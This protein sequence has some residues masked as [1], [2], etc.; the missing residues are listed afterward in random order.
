MIKYSIVVPVYNAEKYLS[1]AV[2]SVLNQSFGNWELV[3]VN[4]G[5]TDGSDVLC[6]D[7][8][9]TDARVKYIKKKNGGVSETRNVGIENSSGEYIVFLDADDW[10]ET[11]C[12]EKVETVINDKKSDILIMNYY[13]A[14]ENSIEKAQPITKSLCGEVTTDI[15]ELIKFTLKL[16]SGLCDKWHGI[17]RPVWAKVFRRDI[18]RDNQITF[19]TQLKIGEDAAFLFHYLQYAK[20]VLYEDWYV[21]YYRDNAASAMNNR[22]WCGTDVSRYYF[23]IV[24]E[25]LKDAI[26]EEERALFWFNIA[27]SDWMVLIKSNLSAV[28]KY[29]EMKKI[30]SD[31]EYQRFSKKELCRHFTKKHKLAAFF[32]RNR[33]P[34]MLL[35]MY[36]V[37]E[38]KKKS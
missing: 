20:T 2:E 3:L 24:E 15:T 1:H 13:R 7:Y 16:S 33:M 17:M 31:M 14:K 5:S 34:V 37:K 27:E 18:I 30:I 25:T 10:L 8:V 38:I 21:Y 29:K 19:D 28:Q 9:K 35:A 23:R 12:L 6:Q 11:D 4:D 36:R 32:I 26:K 22:K